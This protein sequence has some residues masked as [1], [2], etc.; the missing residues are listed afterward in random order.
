M[1]ATSDSGSR[2]PNDENLFVKGQE[3]AQVIAKRTFCQ[4]QGR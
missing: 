1:N 2:H 4:I 3:S